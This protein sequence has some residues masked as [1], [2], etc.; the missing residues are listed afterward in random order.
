MMDR[1]VLETLL[2]HLPKWQQVADPSR[3]P[4]DEAGAMVFKVDVLAM[5]IG[6]HS[7]LTV[8]FLAADLK[9]V[10]VTPPAIRAN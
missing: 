8:A 5:Q 9:A 3:K 2:Q 1:R 4:R 6:R 10:A 7:D